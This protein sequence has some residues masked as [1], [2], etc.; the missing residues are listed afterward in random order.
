MSVT[1][2]KR[3]LAI[4]T[5]QSGTAQCSSVVLVLRDRDTSRKGQLTDQQYCY[6]NQ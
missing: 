3:F 5:E 1:E 2:Y 4:R 6:V